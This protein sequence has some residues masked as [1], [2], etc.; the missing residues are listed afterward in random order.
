MVEGK[1]PTFHFGTLQQLSS[2]PHL[3][4]LLLPPYLPFPALARCL[5]HWDYRPNCERFQFQYFAR[6]KGAA[7]N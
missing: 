7:G 4:S 6:E 2:S 3:L 1:A 5:A